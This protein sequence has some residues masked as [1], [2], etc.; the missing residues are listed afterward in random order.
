MEE[1]LNRIEQSLAQVQAQNLEILS[2]LR[3]RSRSQI[4]AMTNYTAPAWD[5]MQDLIKGAFEPG[6][7]WIASDEIASTLGVSNV[8]MMGRTLKKLGFQ[9]KTVRVGKTTKKGYFCNYKLPIAK[10]SEYMSMWQ[11]NLIAPEL[12]EIQLKNMGF[13]EYKDGFLCKLIEES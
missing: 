12:T 6:S 2:Y 5:K 13:T 9:I 3:P 7:T 1:Q 11:I 8:V 4:R 10:G